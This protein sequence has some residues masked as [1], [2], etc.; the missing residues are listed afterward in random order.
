MELAVQLFCIPVAE[1]ALAEAKSDSKERLAASKLESK[2]LEDRT[3]L[4]RF[5]TWS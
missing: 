1:L 2:I 3:F 4:M 5:E